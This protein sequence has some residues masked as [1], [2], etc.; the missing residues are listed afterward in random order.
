[1]SKNGPWGLV[2]MMYMK[3]SVAK[4]QLVYRTM[5]S[6]RKHFS[7]CICT[8]IAVSWQDISF[9]FYISKLVFR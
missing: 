6:Y 7:S 4:K 8:S 9:D 1:M 5:K 3:G 2:G